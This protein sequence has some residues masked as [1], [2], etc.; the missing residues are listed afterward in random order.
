MI[1]RKIVAAIILSIITSSSFSANLNYRHEYVDNGFNKDRLAFSNTFSNGIGISIEAKFRSDNSNQAFSNTMGNGHEEK[2]SWK[3]N[4]TP[5]I[6]ITP[7]FAIE[8]SD[9]AS[10]Y[11]PRIQAQYTFK[12]S[13]YLAASYRFEKKKIASSSDKPED[14]V[15]K[16][17]LFIGYPIGKFKTEFNYTYARSTENQIRTNNKVYSSEYNEKIAYTLNKL[18]SPFIEIGNV[19]VKNNDNRLTRFRVGISYNF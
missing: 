8:S 5:N 7:S 14:N 18:W 13:A 15:N 19:G 9:S 11:K 3:K 6:M 2:L 16:Y 12:N 1:S 10:T 17:D 4:L